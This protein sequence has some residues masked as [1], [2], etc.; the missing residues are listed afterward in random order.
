MTQAKGPT[1]EL[2][3][4]SNLRA[5]FSIGDEPEI[6][7]AALTR[8][9]WMAVF[10]QL[11]AAL[12]AVTL[13]RLKLPLIP[14]GAVV[15][16]TAM[17]NVALVVLPR[18]GKTPG[19]L[20]LWV[21]LLDVLLLTVLLYLTG[22]PD[23]PFASLYVIHVA[24]GVIVL[25]ARW[26]WVLVMV[27]AACYGV[28]LA[29]HLPLGPQVQWWIPA[30]G[31]WLALVLVSVLITTFIGRVIRSLRQREYELAA[32]RERAARN[33][34]LAALTT[35]AAGAAHELNT[36]LGTIAVVAKELELSCGSGN[37]SNPV[38]DDARLIRREVDRCRTI[39]ERMRVDIGDEVSHRSVLVMSEMEQRLRDVLGDD[40]FSRVTVVRDSDVETVQAPP[41]ALEQA[42][43]VLLRN[44]LD[45][46][47]A[48]RPVHLD[49]A[50][51]DG[52]LRFTVRD[53]GCGMSE[54][55][56]RRAGE[57]FFTTKEP[58]RGMGLGLFLVRL[59]AQQCG[60]TFTMDSKV[61]IGTTCVLEL[62]E[63]VDGDDAIA[64]SP[65]GLTGSGARISPSPVGLTGSGARIAPSP[66]GRGLG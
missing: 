62:P 17:S 65:A 61:G 45:A 57:P 53:S 6:V 32:V 55:M 64:P 56:L 3:G 14:I 21:L 31:N 11:A 29:W 8:L 47:P 27:V 54:E 23:N 66:P 48:P 15:F 5:F 36:P 46:S 60:A 59:V 16:V 18:F 26:V 2:S 28:L 9:R 4:R 12:L 63:A 49:I 37:E 50:R 1:L 38:L 20:V 24:M 19:W 42:L 44:A 52:H 22:G 41:R 58:G 30:V 10:G 35:L 51:Q 25:R 7:L 43:L 13:L 40:N 34:Q 33:E 39:L